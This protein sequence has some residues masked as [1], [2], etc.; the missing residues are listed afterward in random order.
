MKELG[1]QAKQSLL[2]AQAQMKKQYDHY[3]QDKRDYNIGD[4]VWLEAT[5]LK[6]KRPTKKF[7]DKQVGPFTILEKISE[8]AY[9]LK[10]L[11]SWRHH[12]VFN[13]A[14]LTPYIPPSYPS[15]TTPKPPP[16]LDTEGIP[17]YEVEKII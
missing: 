14:L 16:E 12:P 7:D 17:V 6:T 1:E 2:K 4:Q 3:R 8:L 11:P 10:I 15:Q 13:E 9:K 5:N